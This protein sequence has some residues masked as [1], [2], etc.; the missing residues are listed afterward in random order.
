MIGYR[1]IQRAHAV[2]VRSEGIYVFYLSPRA[3]RGLYDS[4]G[5]WYTMASTTINAASLPLLAPSLHS[6]VPIINLSTNKPYEPSPPVL[7]DFGICYAWYGSHLSDSDARGA[8]I[9]L[10]TSNDYVDYILN[11][12]SERF[13]LPFSAASGNLII[14]IEIAGPI[15]NLLS[16]RIIPNMLRAMASFIQ[17]NCISKSGIG[18]FVTLG[19]EKLFTYIT[20]P[21][22]NI[23]RTPYPASTAFVTVMIGS[24]Y[25]Y[26]PPP[27]DYDPQMALALATVEGV[28]EDDAPPA[29]KTVFAQRKAK[30][31]RQALEM[32]ALLKVWWDL[33]SSSGLDDAASD[34]TA[35]EGDNSVA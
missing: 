13:H 15:P 9:R 16:V 26:L 5:L 3:S 2:K 29:R 7:P 6:P 11:N 24:R 22:T 19:I 14:Q 4:C 31:K 32:R 20:E 35:V 18:G 10:P 17:T 33:A 27:G 21:Q 8:G 1:N 25:R 12:S 28:A 30:F 23:A 34:G